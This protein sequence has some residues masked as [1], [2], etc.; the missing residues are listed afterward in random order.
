MYKIEHKLLAHHNTV[1]PQHFCHFL[2]KIKYFKQ[3]TCNLMN[4]KPLKK[5]SKLMLNVV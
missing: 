5:V 1:F 3:K 4:F 2:Y